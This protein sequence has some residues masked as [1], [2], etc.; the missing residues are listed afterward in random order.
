M[1]LLAQALHDLDHNQSMQ[2]QQLSCENSIPWVY[3]SSLINSIKQGLNKVN[4]NY[5]FISIDIDAVKAFH[6]ISSISFL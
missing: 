3:G 2:I 6:M 4:K 5:S 1:K